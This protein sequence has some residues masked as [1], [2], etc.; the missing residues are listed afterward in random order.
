MKKVL[1]A[2]TYKVLG[3]NGQVRL[4]N[5]AS[6]THHVY[7]GDPAKRLR[8]RLD[9]RSGHEVIVAETIELGS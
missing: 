2:G 6:L 4:M 8:E 5:T 1:P 3:V 9:L 7:E